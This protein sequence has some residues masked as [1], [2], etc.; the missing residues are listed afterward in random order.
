MRAESLGLPI[1]LDLEGARV[2]LVG[3]DED[4]T[5]KL[6]LLRDAGADVVQVAP[7]SFAD[8]DA[9]GARVVMLTAHDFA[10]AV[11]VAAAARAR[12]ALVWCSDAPEHSDFA[13]PAVARLGQ[14]RFAI[15]TGGGS[16]A[17]AARIRVAVEEQLGD[18]FGRFVAAL[19]DLRA[20]VQRE[21]PDFER[22]RARLTE[23]LDG[24]A[25]ELRA[26]YPD[27]FRD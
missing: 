5:R 18:A 12:G 2:L 11:R 27:W 20:R 1:T 19:A 6:A 13:M 15:A 22:R 26:R 10:L 3:D 9:D 16:P 17:L 7:A 8:D 21:E 23:A 25:L 4:A 24:F 14:A